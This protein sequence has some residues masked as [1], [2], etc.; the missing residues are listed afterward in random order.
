MVTTKNNP[1]VLN[2]WAVYDIANSVYSLCIAT[3]IF[4]PYYEGITR[5][6]YPLPIADYTHHQF[7][8]AAFLNFDQVQ[9]LGFAFTNTVIYTYA[10]SFAFLLIALVGPILSG[11][12][13]YTG[14][15]K[16]FM[17]F[18]VY[19]GALACASLFFFDQ[20]SLPF[21]AMNVNLPIIA[22]ILGT[23]GFSG[24]AVF[25]N[26]FLPEIASPDRYEGISARGYAMGYAGSVLLLIINLMMI[27]QPQWFGLANGAEAARVSFLT[28]G[29]WWIA[30]S[31]I[32]FY[33]LP[34][35]SKGKVIKK[36]II[37]KGFK[38]LVI[39][40][41][42]LKSLARLRSY[43]TSFFF[44]SMGL[45]TVMFVASIFGKKVL[46]LE[47]SKLI[48]TVMIIQVIAIPG[49]FLFAKMAN[50]IGNIRTLMIGSFIWI[51]ICV[52]AYFTYSEIQFYALAFT[53][54]LVMGGVQSLCRATFAKILNKEKDTSAYFS[55]FDAT[56]KVGIVL[57]TFA[58]GLIDDLF[59]MRQS[60]LALIVFFVFATVLLYQSRRT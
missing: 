43:L 10:L 37:S 13:D 52:A 19:L 17:K 18:F 45:Q 47:T 33:Y 36:D 53:V 56:E 11:I 15:K 35:T 48:V 31:Q 6:R 42:E 2:A 23:V 41:K 12:S 14:H 24:S 30:V 25:Y 1:R 34:S 39:V 20:K 49:S 50:K 5:Q 55:F 38:E 58:Y 4:P 51:G 32:T 7:E 54:G 29:V 8:S 60:V 22:F 27:Q 9:F 3:A 26:S 21:Q 44:I 16:A 28:V 57:G 46:N 59:G 40:F